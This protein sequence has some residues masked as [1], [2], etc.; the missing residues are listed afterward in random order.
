MRSNREYCTIIPFHVYRIITKLLDGGGGCGAG[1]RVAIW[2][3]TQSTV[4]YKYKDIL[5]F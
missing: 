2:S 3:E 4:R 5:Y 1:G